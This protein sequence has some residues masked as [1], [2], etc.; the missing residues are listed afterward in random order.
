MHDQ[1]DEH[2][3]G[4]AKAEPQRKHEPRI[5]PG[6]RLVRAQRDDG[7]HDGRGEHVT[8]GHAQ[9][10][11]LADEAPDD[12][13]AATFADRKDEPEQPREKNRGRRTR[14]QQLRD[15][16]RRH[17]DIHESRDERAEQQERSTLEK[18]AEERLGKIAELKMEP[19]HGRTMR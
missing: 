2:R 12:D 5:L 10:Q 16:L 13:H 3:D 8:G 7:A 19:V 1:S 4:V 18:H 15:A 6:E 11:P 17:E 14:G 9:R